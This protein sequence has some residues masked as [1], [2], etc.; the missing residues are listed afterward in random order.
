MSLTAFWTASVFNTS[1]GICH[2]AHATT[3]VAGDFF[4]SIMRRTLL[5]LKPRNY[6]ASSIV[7]I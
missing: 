6:A 5:A 7:N 4:R 2:G 1:T 3:C